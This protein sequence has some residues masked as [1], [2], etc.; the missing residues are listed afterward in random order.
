MAII[1]TRVAGDIPVQS[2]YMPLISF[3]FSLSIL[4][5]FVSF[6]WFVIAEKLKAIKFKSKFLIGLKRKSSKTAVA[7]FSTAQSA[8]EPEKEE[9]DAQ[10]TVSIMNKLA[11]TF[12][13]LFMFI[14][15]ACIWAIIFN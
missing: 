3:Y 12:I 15:F 8:M 6:V 13:F 7:A 1:S 9:K 10:T 14:S 11:F 2:D 5:T 4:V